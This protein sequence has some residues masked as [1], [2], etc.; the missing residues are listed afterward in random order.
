MHPKRHFLPALLA[1][2]LAVPAIPSADPL[3]EVLA[4]P[5]FGKQRK[6]EKLSRRQL[7]K[8]VDTS[9]PYGRLVVEEGRK[10][11]L[12][13]WLLPTPAKFKINSTEMKRSREFMEFTQVYKKKEE[14]YFVKL[15]V[16]YPAAI[17]AV[18]LKLVRQFTELEPPQL[19]VEFSEDV[20][21][22]E[23]PGRLFLRPDGASILLRLPKSSLL[24]LYTKKREH[25]TEMTEFAR[26]LPVDRVKRLL[27]E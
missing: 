27:E 26:T 19:R 16:P 22:R 13:E 1:F 7:A 24:S 20:M 12:P 9:T 8:Y 23:V 10:T 18:S 2:F 14:E 4:N 3:Q 15:F 17:E 25:A 6:K 11:E 21:I 5:T